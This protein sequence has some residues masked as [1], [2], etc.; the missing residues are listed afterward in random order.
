MSRFEQGYP[1]ASVRMSGPVKF[2]DYTG[3]LSNAGLIQQHGIARYDFR[4]GRAFGFECFCGLV[5]AD[6]SQLSAHA[7]N[8]D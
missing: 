3:Q 4:D 8:A 7:F 5:F 1:V 2:S 6:A